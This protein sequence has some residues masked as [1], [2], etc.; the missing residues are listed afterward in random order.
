V[1]I[2]KEGKMKRLIIII[3]AVLMIGLYAEVLASW[4]TMDN[5]T[6]TQD[7]FGVWGSSGNDVYAVGWGE[8]VLHYDGYTWAEM[9]SGTTRLNDVWGSSSTDVFAVGGKGDYP[10]GVSGP[11]YH[12]DALNW[13]EIY[14]D[15]TFL[16]NI[17]GSLATDIFAV[18][19]FASDSV[20]LHYNGISWS[21][22]YRAFDGLLSGV[23]GSSGND[24]YAVGVH[25]IMHYDGTVWSKLGLSA[26][27]N[28]VWGSSATDVFVVSGEA[29]L[30]Y[31]GNTLSAMET[32]TL[33]D[34]ILYLRDVWGSSGSDVYAVGSEGAI[35]HYNG[36]GWALMNSG[37]TNELWSI[38]GSSSQDVFVVGKEGIVLHYNGDYDSDGIHNLD[39]TCP[40]IPNGPELG[41]CYNAP[42]AGNTCLSTDD[43]DE[44]C[45]NQEDYVCNCKSDFNCDL[46]VDAIDVSEFLNEFG[47]SQYLIPCANDD[48]CRA[49]YA[50]DG[51]VDADDAREFL[52][53]FSGRFFCGPSFCLSPCITCI[54]DNFVYAC[55]YE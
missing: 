38:W 16:M 35:L 20:I 40:L 28:S 33:L 47:R 31:D 54:E 27:G 50:C 39:D 41:I 23:W 5:A 51:D 32:G 34:D 4:T 9:E 37:T 19:G 36:I 49:D 46:N 21:E 45:M 26:G 14:S 7:L 53:D 52:F 24:V 25:S 48:P 8:N 42:D 18:G 12:Y 3:A 2:D 15:S 10:W 29:I 43:C 30:H 22:M 6:T 44:C 17:W 13:S 1:C 55:T 11:I